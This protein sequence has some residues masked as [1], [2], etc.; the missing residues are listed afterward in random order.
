MKYVLL[1]VDTEEFANPAEQA[2]L[3]QRLAWI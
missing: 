1:F 3:Q 2:I